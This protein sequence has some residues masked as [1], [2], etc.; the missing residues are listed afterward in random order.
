MAFQNLC[1]VI[2]P[3]TLSNGSEAGSLSRKVKA[4]DPREQTEMREFSHR[5]PVLPK[6]PRLASSIC[7]TST[8]SNSGCFFTMRN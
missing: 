1:W 2:S 8:K 3:F 6:P 4:A 5:V 7:S